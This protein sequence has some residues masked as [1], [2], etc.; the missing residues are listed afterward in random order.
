M[1]DHVPVMS[2]RGG[3]RDE[4]VLVRWLAGPGD[5]VSAGQPLAVLSVDKADVEVAATTDGEVRQL[6]VT[7]SATVGPDQPLALIGPSRAASPSTG[8]SPDRPAAARPRTTSAATAATATSDPDGTDDP[9]HEVRPLTRIRRRIAH[10]MMTSLSTSAQLTG[11]VEVDVTAVIEV[12]ERHKEAFRRRHGFGLSP[13][14]LL[15]RA[16]VLAAARHPV[17]NASIDV[18]AGTATYHHDVNLGVAVETPTGLLVPNLPAAQDRTTAG[19]ATAIGELAARARRG[20]LRPDDLAGGTFTVTNT[21]SLG[22]LFGTPIL[23]P[24]N[25]AILGTYTATRRPVVVDTDRVALRWMS[26]FCL[27]YDH[28]LIDGADAAAYLQDVRTTV[29]THDFEA[30]LGL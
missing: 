25:A 3:E 14:T 4:F 30:E 10:H 15:A 19:L 23:S 1:S 27:T 20:D 9:R 26:Y 29:E 11:A 12:R 21:G 7:T 8:A 18:E 2:P 16:A 22:T 24:P 13:F 28:Q 17:I 5:P 6:L